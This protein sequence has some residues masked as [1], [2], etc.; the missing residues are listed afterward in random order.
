MI[1]QHIPLVVLF[2]VALTFSRYPLRRKLLDKDHT[3]WYRYKQHPKER[4]SN[5]RNPV[6]S[7]TFQM[8]PSECYFP[9]A[10]FIV[11]YKVVLTFQSTDE[12][13]G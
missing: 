5:S 9:E 7:L 11:L 12:I 3:L 6:Q 2:E 8:K 13:L 1:D 10:L 4:D